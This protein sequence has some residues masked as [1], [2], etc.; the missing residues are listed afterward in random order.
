M[1]E[2]RADKSSQQWKH[3]G[4][5]ES[6]CVREVPAARVS[7]VRQPQTS[8]ASNQ[9]YSF[10]ASVPTDQLRWPSFRWIKFWS[11]PVSLS[12]TQTEEAVAPWGKLFM[13]HGQSTR[14]QAKPHKHIH[15][16]YFH[17][18]YSNSWAKASHRPG[19][20]SGR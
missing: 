20:P 11:V 10:L 13:A 3:T 5:G 1:G 8:V 12:G 6:F 16:L 17:H 7:V 2:A 9:N 4:G 18:V 15:S 19:P 14:C